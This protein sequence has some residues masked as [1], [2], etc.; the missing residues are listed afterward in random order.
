MVAFYINAL[1]VYG[2]QVSPATPGGSRVRE[3]QL[4]ETPPPA[5]PLL[6]PAVLG[7]GVSIPKPCPV[8]QTKPTP[9]NEQDGIWKGET[10]I[11]HQDVPILSTFVTKVREHVY[12][13]PSLLA[14]MAMLMMSQELEDVM[15]GE[16]CS[17]SSTLI[18]SHHRKIRKT[19][20]NHLNNDCYCWT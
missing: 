5:F 8:G 16:G 11:R 4:R 6:P 15:T 12:R 2:C 7:E 1:M 17:D 18:T 14:H 10:G 3:A 19:R 9:Q 13:S 20:S